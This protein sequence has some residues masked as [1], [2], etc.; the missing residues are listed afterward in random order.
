[1]GASGESVPPLTPEEAAVLA[2][3]DRQAE[4]DCAVL[5]GVRHKA[6]VALRC[7]TEGCTGL[8]LICKEHAYVAA[9]SHLGHGIRAAM[10]GQMSVVTCSTCGTTRETLE[11]L[12]EVVQL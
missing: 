9:A 4:P 1:M 7:R 6:E 12:V 11:E 5:T 10:N 8:V 3:L 2:Q